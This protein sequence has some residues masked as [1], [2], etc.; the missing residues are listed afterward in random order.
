MGLEDRAR[1]EDGSVLP[2][3][4]IKTGGHGTNFEKK[5]Y[6]KK[7]KKKERGRFFFSL[8]TLNLFPTFQE[9]EK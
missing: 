2:T 5:N 9:G 4:S 7:V 8:V 6:I 3:V 1:E